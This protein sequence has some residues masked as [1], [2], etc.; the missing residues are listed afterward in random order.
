MQAVKS[1]VEQ[2]Y[3][4]SGVREQVLGRAATAF[5]IGRLQSLKLSY[6]RQGCTSCYVTMRIVVL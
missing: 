4:F 1:A 3:S 6:N 5:G 2:M